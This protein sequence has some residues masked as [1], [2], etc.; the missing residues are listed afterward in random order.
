MNGF[1]IDPDQLT[2]TVNKTLNEYSRN[3]ADTVKEAVSHAAENAVK[4]LRKTSPKKSGKYAKGWG[5][6]RIKETSESITVLIRN[7]VYQLTHL[8]ENGHV[9]RG[10]GRVQGIPHIAPAEQHAEKA[11]EKEIRKGLSDG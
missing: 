3:V 6:V 11:V 10:G 9:K 5:K 1:H 4:E 7:K 8:L 2:K